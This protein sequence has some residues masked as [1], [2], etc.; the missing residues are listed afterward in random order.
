MTDDDADGLSRRD[1]LKLAGGAGVVGAGG[2]AGLQF[3]A[4]QNDAST[5]AVDLPPPVADAVGR[6]L[7]QARRRNEQV[8]D[9]GTL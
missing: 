8:L 7:R 5:T 6:R 1:L 3:F 4:D 2:L 9:A